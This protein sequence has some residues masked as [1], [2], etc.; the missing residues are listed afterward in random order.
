MFRK[1]PSTGNAPVI[2]Y[3]VD[4]DVRSGFGG[5]F[6]AAA[7]TGVLVAEGIAL[8]FAGLEDQAAFLFWTLPLVA[9]TAAIAAALAPRLGRDRPFAAGAI[10]AVV[11][12]VAGLLYTLLVAAFLGPWIGA[13][14]MPVL[15]CWTAGAAMAALAAPVVTRRRAAV[16]A[17]FLASTAFLLVVAALVVPWLVNWAVGGREVQMVVV[18]HVAGS[19]P[20]EFDIQY[21]DFAEPLLTE[22][23]KAQLAGL[24]EG[25]TLEVS[26]GGTFGSGAR[27]KVVLVLREPVDG[28][29]RFPLP[30]EGTLFLV[31]RRGDWKLA[32]HDYPQLERDIVLSNREASW[33][34]RSWTATRFHLEMPDG[35]RSGADAVAWK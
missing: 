21:P 32:P 13:F 5:A 9:A 35:G 34:G 23:E 3:G 31:Q 8:A 30:A 33:E 25:G 26:A 24:V 6:V 1:K 16:A 18:R 22:A 7:A 4:G 10:A 29:Q 14:R 17:P 2:E 12:G 15:L 28:P 19:Q 27:V 11:G 20:V